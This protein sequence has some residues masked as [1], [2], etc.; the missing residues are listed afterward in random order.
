MYPVEIDLIVQ[1]YLL[2]NKMF[3]I[4][5]SPPIKT[6]SNKNQKLNYW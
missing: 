5:I 6:K 4:K 2:I 1:Y 3:K